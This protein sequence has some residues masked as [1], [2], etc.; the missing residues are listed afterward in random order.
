MSIFNL[1]YNKKKKWLTTK[2]SKMFFLNQMSHN[3]NR[4]F[5][6]WSVCAFIDLEHSRLWRIYIC[7]I[8]RTHMPINDTIM[9]GI[10]LSKHLLQQYSY[11]NKQKIKY[12]GYALPII[13][14][15]SW[16]NKKYSLL[17]VTVDYNTTQKC[18]IIWKYQIT[19]SR[20]IQRTLFLLHYVCKLSRSI[21]KKN[22]SIY[23]VWSLLQYITK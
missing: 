3:V 18:L 8:N 6:L 14:S 20:K 13:I 21:G 1:L 10:I 15:F 19:S 16:W 5:I 2:C 7:H 22:I 4:D 17:I 11:D 23:L 12:Q 9:L